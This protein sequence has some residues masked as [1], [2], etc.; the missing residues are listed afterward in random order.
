MKMKLITGVVTGRKE[1]IFYKEIDKEWLAKHLQELSRTFGFLT[2]AVLLELVEMQFSKCVALV[3]FSNRRTKFRVCICKDGHVPQ[4]L[5]A[6]Q[7]KAYLRVY[8]KDIHKKIYRE[9]WVTLQTLIAKA[10]GCSGE[11]LIAD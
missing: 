5:E 10:R 9:H 2:T 1:R 11:I 3:W 8:R 6:F 4:E 7:K